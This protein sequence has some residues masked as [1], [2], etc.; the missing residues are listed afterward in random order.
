MDQSD[1]SF[2]D[3]AA[4]WDVVERH[5]PHWGQPGCMCFVTWR[6]GDALPAEILVQLDVAIG[7]LLRGAGLDPDSDLR[8]QLSQHPCKFRSDVYHKLFQLRDRFLDSGYGACHLANRECAEIVL[9]SLLKFDG[10]RYFMTDVVVM[11]NHAHFLVGFASQTRFLKQC[12]EWKRFSGRAVNR[13][14]GIQGSFWQVDQFDHLLRGEKWF[15]YYRQ[16]IVDNPKKASLRLGEF[17][18]F[19]KRLA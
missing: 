17:L 9:E 18:H 4:D 2:F 1:L 3:P 8:V 7:D 5:L 15:D 11:P 19:Q 13:Y 6:L 14:L 12:T 16:Y 10:E